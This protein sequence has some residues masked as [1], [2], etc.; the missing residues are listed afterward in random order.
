V[1]VARLCKPSKPPRL[2]K[3]ARIYP[4]SKALLAIE[5]SY[6]V[7]L[8]TI[9]APGSIFALKNMGWKDKTETEHS[10]EMKVQTITG[11]TIQ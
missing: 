6:E 9:S 8:R 5:N 2:Q 4:V 11:M 10:G 1:Y 7:T 3:E